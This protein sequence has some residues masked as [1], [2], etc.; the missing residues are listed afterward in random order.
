MT[1]VQV[2]LIGGIGV[3]ILLVGG[4]LLVLTRRRKVVL[5]SP[6]DEK[7]TD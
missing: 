6:T 2:G 4:A 3:I 1:G 5:V 7:S